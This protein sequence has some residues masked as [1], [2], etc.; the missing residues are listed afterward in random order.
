MHRLLFTLAALV[1]A[2]FATPALAQTNAAFTGVRAELQAG[3]D[4]LHNVRDTNAINYGA[5]VG[6]DVP[7]GSRFTAGVEGTAG[8]V[9][10][11]DRLF[12]VGARLGFAATPRT[13]LYAGAGYENYRSFRDL[14]GL[15]ISGGIE[16]TLGR[17]SFA[18]IEARYSDLDANTGRVGGLIG[19]GLRF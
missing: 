12:G 15:R 18:R 14:E 5:A 16:Q 10:E 1:A 7:L 6:V 13:L 9:F 3:A 19:I 4:D 11:S 8:N 2:T 17:N